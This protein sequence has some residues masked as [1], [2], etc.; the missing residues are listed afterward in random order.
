[1]GRLVFS[2][3]EVKP[4][5]DHTLTAPKQGEVYG[6]TFTEP[7]VLLV[8]DEGVYLM[9][10]GEPRQENPDKRDTLLLVAYALGCDPRKGDCWDFCREL[11][12]GDDFGE[13]LPAAWFVEPCN[14]PHAL[15]EITVG[16]HNLSFRWSV[17]G[18][19]KTRK[20]RKGVACGTVS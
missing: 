1:M 16:E 15:I 2:A 4:I 3:A 18:A 17:P 19:P 5:L 11:V 20:P 6:R 9:S 13:P 8:H 10:N 7:Q 12:G 14:T